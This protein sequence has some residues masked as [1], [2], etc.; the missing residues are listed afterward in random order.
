[1]LRISYANI[2]LT[3]SLDNHREL[4]VF[5][6][7][8]LSELYPSIHN[9]V[10][11]LSSERQ[12]GQLHLLLVEQVLQTLALI[13][14]TTTHVS[15]TRVGTHAGLI[16][17]ASVVGDTVHGYP[18]SLGVIGSRQ[19][20]DTL[21]VKFAEIGVQLLPVLFGQLGAEAVQSD[22][23]TPAIC[24]EFESL[25]HDFSCRCASNLGVRV[26][27]IV[28]VLEVVLVESVSDNFDVEFVQILVTEGALE[29]CSKWCLD[30]DR[31]VEFFDV[32]GHAE[33]GHG[34][35]PAEWVAPIEQF[36]RIS[37][38]QGASD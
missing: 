21:G 8:L 15:D 6:T 16:E 34:L 17:E 36:S 13:T 31:V 4:L 7:Y 30:E 3:R 27:P 25:G 19:H 23:D 33:G 20:Q 18:Y 14:S 2:S 38:M 1:M 24:L 5:K 29:I 26:D 28:E 22:V 11:K 32:G 37:F 9:R 12:L 10:G 35:E